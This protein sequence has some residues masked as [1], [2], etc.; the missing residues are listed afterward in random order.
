[1]RLM[2]PILGPGVEPRNTWKQQGHGTERVKPAAG[3]GRGRLSTHLRVPL[4][5]SPLK[6]KD[7]RHRSEKPGAAQCP[8]AA[9][10]GH[11]FIAAI[12]PVSEEAPNSCSSPEFQQANKLLKGK[13]IPLNS[14]LGQADPGFQKCVG[15]Y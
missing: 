10:L 8:G 7:Q 1:M 14:A 4:P 9:L 11:G 15:M 12:T 5:R 2:M 13:D 3:E 6:H